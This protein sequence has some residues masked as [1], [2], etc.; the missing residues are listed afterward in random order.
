MRCCERRRESRALI[1]LCTQ[2]NLA[3]QS[4]LESRLLFSRMVREKGF[5]ARSLV[6]PLD[7]RWRAS[8]SRLGRRSLDGASRATSPTNAVQGRDRGQAT[9]AAAA[10]LVRNRIV[11]VA[12]R[13]LGK[14]ELRLSQSSC[15]RLSL[16]VLR[17]VRAAAIVSTA[18][19]PVAIWGAHTSRAIAM[20]IAS[21]DCNNVA[22]LWRAQSLAVRARRVSGAGRRTRACGRNHYERRR[23]LSVKDLAL[24]ASER[25]APT[26]QF[27]GAFFTRRR[28]PS[29]RAAR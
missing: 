11:R 15:A 5:R 10:A 9:A 6:A 7:D 22:T 16:R 29:G 17:L 4:A 8:A 24:A 20:A 3:Q 19:A 26:S 28:Q 13:G 14:G 21:S 25:R 12:S 2:L 23:R 1:N 18:A 27:G